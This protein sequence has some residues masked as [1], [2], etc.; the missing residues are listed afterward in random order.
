[1]VGIDGGGV[2]G[3]ALA[4]STAVTIELTQARDELRLIAD[5]VTAAYDA[6]PRR[7][8]S[9][10]RGPASNAYQ[11]GL[12]QLRRDIEGALELLRSAIDLTNAA[13]FELGSHV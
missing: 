11:H 4:S 10:W 9:G 7:D 8:A 12:D 6:A 2:V 1:V 13:L 3:G 5:R